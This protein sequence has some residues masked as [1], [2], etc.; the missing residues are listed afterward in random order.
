MCHFAALEAVPDESAGK[1]LLPSS[2]AVSRPHNPLLRQ[3]PTPVR[4]EAENSRQSSC[5]FSGRSLCTQYATN[6]SVLGNDRMTTTTEPSLLGN[7]TD[8]DLLVRYRNFDDY[9][10]LAELDR[11]Y[12]GELLV[13]ARKHLPRPL[14][15]DAEDMVQEALMMFHEERKRYAPQGG[16]RSLLYLIVARRCQDHLDHA[17]AEKRDYR[18]TVHPDQEGLDRSTGKAHDLG[19]ARIADPRN[20]ELALRSD[21][22]EMLE[23]LKPEIAQAVKLTR[24]EGHSNESA[25]ELLGTTP[26]AVRGRTERG[27]STLRQMAA[28]LVVLFVIVGA[29]AD[30]CDQEFCA[31]LVPA[32]DNQDEAM[33]E[34]NRYHQPDRLHLRGRPPIR[35]EIQNMKEIANVRHEPYFV[36]IAG[37]SKWRNPLQIGQEWELLRSHCNARGS[38]GLLL[39][40]GLF[41]KRD[42]HIP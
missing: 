38:Y 25:A 28:P 22:D 10:A 6:Q 32:E 19:F 26:T 7:A 12:H 3:S 20:A 39:Q 14:Q 4:P 33:W 23:T 15:A 18:R 41:G 42:L 34:D 24:I 31:N 1:L 35:P 9:A 21:V 5:S 29:V 37:P 11:R 16:V 27:I 2:P 17:G 40:A 30:D 36:L 13:H 8:D